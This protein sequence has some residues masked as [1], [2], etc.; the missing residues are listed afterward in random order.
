MPLDFIIDTG[1]LFDIPPST[2]SLSLCSTGFKI[3]GKEALAL[4]A[5]AKEPFSISI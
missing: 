2:R 3:V 1:K 4:R 5:F